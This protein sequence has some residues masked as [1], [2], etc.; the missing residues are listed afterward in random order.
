MSQ[1]SQSPTPELWQTEGTG[2]GK[3]PTPY[4]PRAGVAGG[5]EVL[6][7]RPEQP[8]EASCSLVEPVPDEGPRT[9]PAPV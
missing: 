1:L 4:R 7:L 2:R 9:H 3:G 6:L 5:R 8:R